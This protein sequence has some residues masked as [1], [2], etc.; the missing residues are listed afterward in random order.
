MNIAEVR[1]GL[2]TKRGSL[3]RNAWKQ[4]TLSDS[5]G[6]CYRVNAIGSSLSLTY[7]YSH[8][9]VYKIKIDNMM[10]SS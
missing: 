2:G 3:A 10:H 8:R 6:L 9:K 1:G 7:H 5:P 4:S